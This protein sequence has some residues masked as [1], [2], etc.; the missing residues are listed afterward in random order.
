MSAPSYDVACFTFLD[1]IRRRGVTSMALAMARLRREQ[2]LSRSEAAA[3][4]LRWAEHYETL[5]DDSAL[6]TASLMRRVLIERN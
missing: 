3:V 6:V 5:Y 4:L 1:S 2:H